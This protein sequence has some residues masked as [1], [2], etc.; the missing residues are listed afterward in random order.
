M[1]RNIDIRKHIYFPY[2]I[3]VVPFANWLAMDVNNIYTQ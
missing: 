1:H 3:I 2:V